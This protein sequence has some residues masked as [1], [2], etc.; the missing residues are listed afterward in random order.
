VG[1]SLDNRTCEYVDH[2]HEHFLHPVNVVRGRY[3]PPTA[4]GY[5]A[6]MKAES[7]A[8]YEYPVGKAWTGVP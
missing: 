3:M 5:S 2:L 4:P 7:L 8:T 1:G 6:E